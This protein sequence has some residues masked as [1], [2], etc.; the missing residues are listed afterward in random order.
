MNEQIF[1]APIKIVSSFGDL[2]FQ[3]EFHFSLVLCVLKK[4]KK[5]RPKEGALW[6]C[7]DSEARELVL[8]RQNH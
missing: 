7:R 6:Y 1:Y 2:D 4:N 8:G 5:K 3:I